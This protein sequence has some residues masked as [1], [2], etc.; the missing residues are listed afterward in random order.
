[1]CW[2]ADTEHGSI[3]ELEVNVFT[4]SL[5]VVDVTFWTSQCH[6]RGRCLRNQ[7]H[8]TKKWI[9]LV[10]RKRRWGD[11]RY[12]R[13]Y[14]SLCRILVVAVVSNSALMQTEVLWLLW[15]L[16]CHLRLSYVSPIPAVWTNHQCHR[17]YQIHRDSVDRCCVWSFFLPLFFFAT[18]CFWNRLPKNLSGQHSSVFK[19]M[20]WCWYFDLLAQW[21]RTDEKGNGCY[22]WFISVSSSEWP[23]FS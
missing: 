12:C 19:H 15:T 14:C 22:V 4:F 7:S 21:N 8:P 1:M 23:P 5:T 11:C 16:R 17:F 2:R 9:F 13:I 3:V 20:S 18:P 10:V 6:D